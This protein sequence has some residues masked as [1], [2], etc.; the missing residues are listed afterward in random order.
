MEK[1][2]VQTR[3]VNAFMYAYNLGIQKIVGEAIKSF[4][5]VAIT[6]CGDEVVKMI[7][8]KSVV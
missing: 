5:R 7:D 8:R 1:K 6:T 3:F 2:F 4:N